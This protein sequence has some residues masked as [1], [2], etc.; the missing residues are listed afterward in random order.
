[1]EPRCAEAFQNCG[2]A[3]ANLGTDDLAAKALVRASEAYDQQGTKE[4]LDMVKQQL[5]QLA[6]RRRSLSQ[7]QSAA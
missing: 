1:L 7:R 3:Y 2:L 4:G 5:E 6:A